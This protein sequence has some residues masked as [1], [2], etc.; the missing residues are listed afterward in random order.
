METE[1]T[2]KLITAVGLHGSFYRK[3][4][5]LIFITSTSYVRVALENG[6]ESEYLRQ[7]RD[8]PTFYLRKENQID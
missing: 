2:L 6:S 3:D 1:A 4:R 7:G 5:N 8:G